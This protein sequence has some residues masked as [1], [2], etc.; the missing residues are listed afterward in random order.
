MEIR[1]ARVFLAVAEELHFGRAAERLYMAQP[2]VTRIIK[3]LERS[4]G[5]TL[6]ERSTRRVSLTVQGEALIAPARQLLHVEAQVRRT[7]KAAEAGETGNLKLAFAG[8]STHR[9]ISRLA[10]RVRRSRP[11]ISLEI[12]S[13]HF[14]QSLLRRILGNEIDIGFGRWDFLPPGVGTRLI[15]NETLVVAFPAAHPLA[16][17]DGVRMAQLQQETFVSLPPHS[18]AVL[19][20]RLER[21]ARDAGFVP[22]VAQIAPDTATAMAMVAAEIGPSLTLSTVAE[23]VTDPHVRF[24]SLLDTTLPVQLRMAWRED[25]EQEPALRAVLAL[26]EQELPTPQAP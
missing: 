26:S 3:E 9:S 20:D 15:T 11:G 1:Q 16:S 6:F 8:A 10:R 13:Q 14:A 4:L 18:G 23:Q 12:H 5:T 7:V 17:S 2:P 25:A 22:E 21:T 19:T 24:V